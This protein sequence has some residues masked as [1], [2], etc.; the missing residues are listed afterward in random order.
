[1]SLFFYADKNFRKVKSF[2][3]N[4]VSEIWAKMLLANQIT[5]F[6]NQLYLQK[7]R[8]KKPDFLHVDADS[9]KIEFD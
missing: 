3:K 6:L 2:G 4:L 1:M 5:R 8:M 9:W 7:K